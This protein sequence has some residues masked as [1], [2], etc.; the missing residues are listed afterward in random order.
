[1]HHL[2]AGLLDNRRTSHHGDPI[3]VYGVRGV[4]SKLGSGKPFRRERNPGMVFSMVNRAFDRALFSAWIGNG[5]F[6]GAKKTCYQGPDFE[7]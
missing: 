5:A 2:A 7:I 3:A 1:L 6:I 4:D